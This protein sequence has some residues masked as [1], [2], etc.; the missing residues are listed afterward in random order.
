[1]KSLEDAD[2]YA[3]LNASK[4]PAFINDWTWDNGD[5]DNI[6]YSLFTAPRAVSRMGYQNAQVNNLN[7]QAQVEHDEAKRTGLY[8][9]AQQLIMKDA[10]MVVL[11]YP[12][13]IIGAKST[14]QNLKVD[15][16][17]SIVLS[18]ISVT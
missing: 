6:M 4:A 11:G 13:R 12:S 15:P 16:T 10:I 5:P 7:V 17:G 8:D 3:Q 9:Q 2:F 14:V 1:M 18:E